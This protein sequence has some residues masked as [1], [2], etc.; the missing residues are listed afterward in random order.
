[1]SRPAPS[2][3]GYV[4]NAFPVTSESFLVN[5]LRGVEGAGVRTAILALSRRRDRIA[6]SGS[7]LLEADVFRPPG[8]LPWGWTDYLTAHAR[9][10][11]ARPRSYFGILRDDLLRPWFRYIRADRQPRSWKRCSKR[12][13]LFFLAPMVASRARRAGVSHLHAHYA[14]EPLEVAARVSWLTGIT[15]SFAAHAKDLYTTPPGRLRRRLAKARFALTCHRHGDRTL[16]TIVARRDRHKIHLVRHGLDAGVFRSTSAQR[17]PLLIV[18]AGR[19]TPKKGFD[20]LIDACALLRSQLAIECV[21]LG[22]GR[23]RRKLERQVRVSG[24]TETIRLPGSVGQ[25]ELARWFRRARVVTLPARVLDDGNRDGVPNVLVEA[26]AC[27]APVVSTS[28]GSI[29]ELI[30]NGET[31]L[32]VPPDD[33]ETLAATLRGVLCSDTAAETLGRQGRLAVDGRDLRRSGRRVARL[34]RRQIRALAEPRPGRFRPPEIDNKGMAKSARR[35][36]GRRPT[37]RPGVEKAIARTV[38]PGLEANSWRVDLRRMTERRI[39][40]E[41]FKVRRAR[42]LERFAASRGARFDGA[43]RVL[44]V[45]CGRGGLSVSL[46]VRGVMAIPLDLRLRNCHVSRLRASRYDLDLPA[47]CGRVEELPFEAGSFDIVCLLEVL[48]HVVDPA[49]LLSEA[50]RVC[51]PGGLCVVT[52]VNRWAH[53]DPHYHLWGIN[54]LPRRWAEAILARTGRAKRSWQDNQRLADMHYYSFGSFRR[55]AT[56]A[57]FEVYDP[58]CPPRPLARLGHQLRRQISLGFNTV[59]LILEPR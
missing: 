9:C 47:L 52:V 17:E 24:L 43:T 15:Y 19:L 37:L 14:K 29:G 54:F 32:L 42:E 11:A 59:T 53:V 16:R 58:G 36:L 28:V 49:R 50:R 30:D 44:D 6:P 7:D 2:R 4:V 10:L 51:R 40:D 3:I 1:M 35:R 48:E 20:T 22:E 57:G 12:W 38:S 25:E 31:G 13:Q 46:Q 41:V 26:M 21:I 5:E 27:G 56:S 55:F 45:G 8:L 23:L 18:A 33:P 34:H 39:W